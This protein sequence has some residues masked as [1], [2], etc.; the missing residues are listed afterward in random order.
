MSAIGNVLVTM[1]VKSIFEPLVFSYFPQTL[2]TGLAQSV[3]RWPFKPVV[4]GSSPISGVPHFV[5]SN[6]SK[7]I[8]F[9]FKVRNNILTILIL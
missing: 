1:L 3:E 2:K 8:R 4:V 6:H 5:F 7:T 9:A